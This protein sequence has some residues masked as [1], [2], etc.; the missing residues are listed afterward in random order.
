MRGTALRRD[1]PA[2]YH[3]ALFDV[4]AELLDPPAGSRVDTLEG[5]V[6]HHFRGAGPNAVTRSP[7]SQ[8]KGERVHQHRLPR[9]GLSGKHVETGAKLEG[10]IG[11]GG[12]VADP[13]LGDHSF[14]SR[15][16]RSPQ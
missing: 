1:F 6:D 9:S 8:E 15:P 4:E 3:P 7:L 10:D 14:N 2:D 11:D 12:E 16:E 13:Q 5:P